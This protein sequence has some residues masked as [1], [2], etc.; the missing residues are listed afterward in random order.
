MDILD[1]PVE[2]Q[3]RDPRRWWALAGLT[4]AVL[5][6]GIDGTVLSVA[7]PTLATA[8]KASESQLQWF[9]SGY[10]LVLAAAMLPAGLLGDRFG[11]RRLLVVALVLF[12]GGSALCAYSGS[13]AVFIAARVILGIGGAAVVVMA[14]SSLAIVFDEE[15]R[16]KAVGVWAAANFVSMPIGPI[17]G[18]WL[19]SHYWWGWVFLL[20]VPVALL[21]LLAARLLLPESHAPRRPTFD[22]TG[23]MLAVGGLVAATYGCIQAGT[24]GWGS[25]L[26]LG[27]LALGVVLLVGFALW[28]RAVVRRGATPLIDPELFRSPAYCWGVILAV[29][30][31][32]AMIGVMF[33]LPQYFQGVL[34]TDAM[35]SGLRL[36]PLIGG[37]TIGAVP[38]AVVGRAIG[39]GRASA[40][41][42]LVLAAAL[43]VGTR[44]GAGSQTF[45]LLWTAGA[46]AGVGL[47]MA[48]SASAALSQLGAEQSGIGSAAMQALNKLGGP[49]GSAVM[50]SVLSAG[51]LGRLVLGGVPAAAVPAVRRSVFGGVAV[52]Q[53]LH[54]PVLLDSVRRAFTHGMDAALVVSGAVA[55]VG[56]VLSWLFLPNRLGARSAAA[57]ADTGAGPVVGEAAAALLRAPGATGA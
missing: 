38:A 36:L 46:G 2:P 21:G 24:D 39:M 45:V 50:G 10:F 20:N 23:L 33:T 35:G 17:L 27:L 3:R 37:M 40:L 34:G 52:A 51:Y 42:F 30:V 18:G 1:A 28:E 4:L 54:S 26:V 53:H 19:L 43:F 13:A 56:A 57:L 29:V 5:A 32:L 41:G 6:V 11:R 7:L 9:T 47:A 31:V 48:T 16:P 15:E 12:A 49:F 14:M 25:G 22:A 44:T 8:L 55:V